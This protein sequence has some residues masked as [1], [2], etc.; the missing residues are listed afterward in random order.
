MILL[1]FGKHRTSVYITYFYYHLFV[2][3]HS[4]LYIYLLFEDT[5]KYYYYHLI[6][7]TNYLLKISIHTHKQNDA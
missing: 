2:Y 1:F 4:Y 3:M 6:T 5:N 7:L